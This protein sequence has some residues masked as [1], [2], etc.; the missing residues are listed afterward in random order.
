MVV[1]IRKGADEGEEILE[2]CTGFKFHWVTPISFFAFIIGSQLLQAFFYFHSTQCSD[3]FRSPRFTILFSI[4]V[5]ILLITE[6]LLIAAARYRSVKMYRVVI[7]L[8]TASIVLDIVMFILSWVVVG[9]IFF[10]HH[11]SLPYFT[12]LVLEVIAYGYYYLVQGL[13][14]CLITISAT[15]DKKH[16]AECSLYDPELDV[17]DEEQSQ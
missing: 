9:F 16:L 10:T 3:F 7:R 13:V 15:N 2:K 14:L 6:L 8:L 12:R 5:S 17:F 4:S 11:H 1:D